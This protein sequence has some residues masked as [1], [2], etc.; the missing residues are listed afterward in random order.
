[1]KDKKTRKGGAGQGCWA[2][3]GREINRGQEGGSGFQTDESGGIMYGHREE[4]AGGVN[5][6]DMTQNG[7]RDN[8]GLTPA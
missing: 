4:N 1:V 8:L 3:Q 6:L 2:L 7:A 5:G